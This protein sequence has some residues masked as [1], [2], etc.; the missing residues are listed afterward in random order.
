MPERHH[1]HHHRHSRDTRKGEQLSLFFPSKG[2]RSGSSNGVA[3]WK[4]F[5]Q[6]LCWECDCDLDLIKF[7]PRSGGGTAP[8]QPEGEHLG[9][10]SCCAALPLLNSEMAGAQRQKITSAL[11]AR[12][13]ASRLGL[14]IFV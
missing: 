2:I 7:T 5:R 9:S 11:C 4:K 3:N 14:M 8:S 6:R 10:A 13:P 1:P 12:P